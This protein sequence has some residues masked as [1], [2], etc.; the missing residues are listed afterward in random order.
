MKL[1]KI[2]SL[3]ALSFVSRKQNNTCVILF[4]G[5]GSNAYDLSS[6]RSV[7]D[8]ENK[9][10]WYFPQGFLD[11]DIGMGH[12]GKG[13][14]PLDPEILKELSHFF[15]GGSSSQEAPQRGVHLNKASEKATEFVEIIQCSYDKI[16]IG[17]YSQGAMLAL[18]ISWN[19]DKQLSQLIILSG[20]CVDPVGSRKKLKQCR[21]FSFFQSHGVYDPRLPHQLGQ[22]LYIMLKECGHKGQLH[23]FSG[24]HEIPETILKSLKNFLVD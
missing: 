4:H 10:D 3:E 23:S 15:G 5:Y 24:G 11:I 14:A 7:L 13:W 19:F 9:F 18:D 12:M 6:L 8:S 16:I 22:K 20:I 2:A 17:G 1:Q 21:P